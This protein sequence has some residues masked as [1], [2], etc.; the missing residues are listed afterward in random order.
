ML[1]SVCK[2]RVVTSKIATNIQKNLFFLS[3][4]S[5]YHHFPSL[6]FLPLSLLPFSFFCY[7]FLILNTKKVLFQHAI[8][9]NLAGEIP[10]E[11]PD[12]LEFLICC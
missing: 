12:D 11:N 1:A 9:E 4:F 6:S 8:Y 2:F 7:N 10:R 5:P 3:F